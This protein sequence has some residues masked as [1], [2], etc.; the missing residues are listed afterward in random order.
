MK[1]KWKKYEIEIF[2]T[3]RWVYEVDAP[4]EKV[5]LE[6][7]ERGD[8]SVIYRDPSQ[9][10]PRVVEYNFKNNGIKKHEH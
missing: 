8:V 4:N 7:V 2:E 9:S 6:I 5:A 3:I 1:K 10:T